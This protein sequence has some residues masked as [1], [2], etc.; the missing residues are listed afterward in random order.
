MISEI[1]HFERGADPADPQSVFL[2][3]FPIGV[4]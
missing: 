1:G 4:S 3:S 2:T